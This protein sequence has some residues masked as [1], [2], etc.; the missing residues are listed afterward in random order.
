MARNGFV[1]PEGE[2]GLR[3]Q[4]RS[5]GRPLLRQPASL[6]DES[7]VLGDGGAPYAEIMPARDR[8]IGG[9]NADLRREGV[10]PRE[11]LLRGLV[12]RAR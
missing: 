2:G 11:V 9:L 1:S 8:T 5:A 3:G 6:H 7:K 10:Q 12:T 4:V